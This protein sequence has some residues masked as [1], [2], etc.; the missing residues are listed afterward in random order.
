MEMWENGTLLG[1]SVLGLLSA[2]LCYCVGNCTCYFMS[3]LLSVLFDASVTV[4]VTVCVT[5]SLLLYIC[6]I[7]LVTILI[8][9]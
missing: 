5:V 4:L 2:V 3:V 7:V 6:C 8:F 1:N 9:C